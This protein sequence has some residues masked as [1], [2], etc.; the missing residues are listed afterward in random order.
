MNELFFS[1]G[2]GILH[3]NKVFVRRKYHVTNGVSRYSLAVLVAIVCSGSEFGKQLGQLLPTKCFTTL[4][5]HSDDVAWQT[6]C[7]QVQT[8]LA[9]VEAVR[10]VCITVLPEPYKPWSW[11]TEHLLDYGKPEFITLTKNGDP[12]ICC[13]NTKMVWLLI[14]SCPMQLTAIMGVMNTSGLTEERRLAKG[15]KLSFPGPLTSF[16]L[17][18]VFSCKKNEFIKSREELLILADDDRLLAVTRMDNSTLR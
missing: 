9:D 10:R 15:A 11:L 5:K 16:R 3:Q 14:G 1:F 6:V 2:F 18:D 12:V 13:P 17:A 7:P 8:I 4:D